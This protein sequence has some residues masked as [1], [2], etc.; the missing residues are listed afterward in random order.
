ME[1]KNILWII[2]KWTF[3]IT[4]GARVATDSLVR[5]LSS[6]GANIDILCLSQ[7]DEKINLDEMYSAWKV[8]DIK[9]ISRD[10]NAKNKLITYLK[11]FFLKPFFPLTISTF[12]NS[13]INSEI[14][15]LYKDKN[16][17]C[18]V[19]DGLHLCAPFMS[20]NKLIKPNFVKKII[21]RAHNIEMD[22]WKKAAK[23]SHNLLKKIFLNYQYLLMRLIELEVLKK[24]NLIAA[25][26]QEDLNQI[27]AL[28]DSKSILVPLGLKFSN[29]LPLRSQS[30][31]KIK[32]LFV[33]KLDWPPNR[34]GLE[35]FL[36]KVWKK[37]YLLNKNLHLEVVGSGAR[38]W[39]NQYNSLPN[40]KITGFVNKIEDAYLD[41][42]YTIVPIF[43]GSGTRIKVIETFAFGRPLISTQMG[44]QGSGL[45]D[46]H[47]SQVETEDDWVNFLG[48]LS[49]NE[50]KLIEKMETGFAKLSKELE[51]KNVALKFY[52]EI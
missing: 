24:S 36:N 13:K 14:L 27:K 40:L 19:L 47:Y 15:R 1:S 29:K 3:P 37:S 16:Y 25:I 11:N 5:N 9:V 22:L 28:T 2:P 21:Y 23:D 48:N 12:S 8:K 33:G 31:S 20:F 44:V 50:P 4:D 7:S 35:W 26:A 45:S 52:S 38:D 10:I 30:D 34:D 39:L 49:F 6:Q 17:D 42:D 41:A 18:M 46:Q 43:Y 51:E 32:I